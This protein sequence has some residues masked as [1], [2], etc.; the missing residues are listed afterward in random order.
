MP[1]LSLQAAY[2][3]TGLGDAFLQPSGHLAQDPVVGLVAEGTVDAEETIEIDIQ[4]RAAGRLAQRL[5]FGSQQTSGNR[6]EGKIG[7]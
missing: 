7:R 2:D 3:G 6:H 5:A 4:Q 1:N